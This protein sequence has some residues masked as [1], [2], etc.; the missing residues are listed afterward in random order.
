MVDMRYLGGFRGGFGWPAFPIIWGLGFLRPSKGK[1]AIDTGYRSLKQW[2]PIRNTADGRG[3]GERVSE[4]ARARQRK[5]SGGGQEV[6]QRR[7]IV[8]TDQ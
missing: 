3:E 7:T 8:L 1:G 4:G 6:L 2:G 5:N